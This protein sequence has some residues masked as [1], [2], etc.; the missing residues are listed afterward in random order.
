VRI[1]SIP[2]IN[3]NLCAIEERDDGE[4]HLDPLIL[5]TTIKTT[6]TNNHFKGVTP[7]KIQSNFDIPLFE[8]KMDVDALDK[9]LKLLEGYYFVQNKFYIENITFALLKVLL[10]VKDWWEIY[11]KDMTKMSLQH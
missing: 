2:L 9:W 7:F 1:F 4:F 10:H 6:S 5:P 3:K 11:H 8:G